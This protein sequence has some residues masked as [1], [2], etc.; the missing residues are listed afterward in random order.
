MARIGAA[1]LDRLK[2]EIAV[3]TLVEESGIALRRHG[4]DLIGHCPFHEDRT[5]SL[6]VTPSKNLW[7]CLGACRTGGTAIDWVMRRDRVSFRHAVEL[8]QR[9]AGGAPIEASPHVPLLP[10]YADDSALLK[11]VVLYYHDT[12]KESP[13][14]VA[15]LEQRGLNSIEAIDH[16]QLGFSNRTL[17]YRLPK[18][19]L[20][21]GAEMRSRLQRIGIL[22]E[23]G[24]EHMNGS[25]TIPVLDDAG[26][27]V[28]LYGR[29]IT[30]G[31]RPGTPLHMYLP[32]PHRGV[33]NEDALQSSKEIIL[34]EALLD[35]LTFWCAGHR[36]VT[37]SY[38]VSG[39]TDDHRAA[40]RKY[41]IERV[42]IAYDRDEAGDRAA[43]ALAKELMRKGIECYRILFPTGLDANAYAR[44]AGAG[45]LAD[46]IRNA[47][48]LGRAPVT[49]AALSVEPRNNGLL[50][51]GVAG[52]GADVV[53]PP[54]PSLLVDSP[55]VSPVP[56]ASMPLLP[57]D[58]R[59]REIVIRAGDRSYRVRG[60]D[61]N[62]S[63]DQLRVNLL[64][65]QG[66]VVHV[67][68]IDLYAAKQRAVYVKQAATELHADENVLKREVG[69]VLL[70]LETVQESLIAKTL[71]PE[72]RVVEMSADDEAAA[73][74][75]LKAPDLLDQVLL[76]FERAGV[77]GE[78]TNK[79]VGYLASVSRKLERPLAVIIQSSSAA[80]KTS[81]MD[82]VLSFVPEEERIEYSAMTGQSL[83]YMSGKDLRHKVLAIVE[84]EGAERA[85]YALKLLQSEG[86]LS[87]A[88]TGKDPHTGRLVTE[89]Y[90]VE[91][92]VAIMLT[93]TATDLDEEL[94]N[95]ALVLGVDEEREQTRRVHERQR[96][97]R[98]LAG[99]LAKEERR[100]L[101]HLHQNAQ[102]LLKPLAIVNPFAPQLTFLDT[103]TRTRRDHEKYLT[104]IDSIALLHQHQREI[105][106]I[107]RGSASIEYIEATLA[108]IAAANHL[109]G[110]VLGRS[111]DELPPQTRR[112]LELLTDWVRSAS[113][114]EQS[115]AALN[116]FT[117]REVRDG[118]RTG[119]TQT[120]IHLARLT[121]LEYVIAHR[122]GPRCVY[123]LLYRGEGE[124]G[125]AF[126]PGLLDLRDLKRN[127]NAD[128]SASAMDRSGHGR[129]MAGGVS[130]R[131][132]ESVEDLTTYEINR[133]SLLA[134]ESLSESASG[135]KIS[136]EPYVHAG[137]ASHNG[138]G[139]GPV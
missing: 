60:L 23:S 53:D 108:D 62:L 19:V 101:V 78:E 86:A 7:H 105:K 9:R 88:S 63:P 45:A 65:R 29:K 27:V 128:R 113:E 130:E 44:K 18:K 14:A 90:R 54:A 16:F 93:T 110:A 111:L 124:E 48:W 47:V 85:S 83:F 95:R 122:N 84:E 79:L 33:W 139:H 15:Y 81:L 13:E 32:G 30:E 58:V 135:E 117:A 42:L 35:A 97:R 98:T 72:N 116:R 137:A 121:D 136:L 87:I 127:Y 43:E 52:D 46:R 67:D 6:V 112:F 12:L 22:R 37:T 133:L 4:A 28:G 131:S 82:A 21:A 132:D 100:A 57:V 70:Q 106:R 24:H 68:T 66:E 10:A 77:V 114:R 104:L 119:A 80:G 94:L 120:K 20:K 26:D 115:D 50:S 1:E 76:A 99:L 64:V 8:L 102:R 3:S 89:E 59:E 134:A 92:P 138:N 17:G 31:L 107:E 69:Q 39:F 71:S 40:F 73:L 74:A 103:R 126:L 36:N 91:G 55:A 123:E 51:V 5:P 38:G 49:S 11:E 109:A 41:G 75:L 118:L 34:C 25:L 61:K 125:D 56:P 129:P 96:A 2:R